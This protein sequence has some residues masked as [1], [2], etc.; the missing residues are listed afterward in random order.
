MAQ[1]LLKLEGVSK[2]FKTQQVLHEIDLEIYNGEFVTLLGPSGCGKTTILRMIGGFET[3]DV[4]TI[5]MEGSNLCALPAN[6][7]AVNTVFQSY[8]LFPHMSVFDNIAFGLKM[9]HHNPS[10]I[11][12]RVMQMLDMVKLTEHAYKKPSQLSGGQQQRVAIARAVINQPKI[13]LL[14]ESLSA[15]D[16]K[17]RK[18]MQI[19]LKQLQR[20]LGIT[21][22]FVTHDQEE[23][24]SMSDRIVV[25]NA[26]HIEQT[27]TPKQIYEEPKNL[28]VA[29]FIGEVNLFTCNLLVQNDTKAQLSHLSST[30]KLTVSRP[31]PQKVNVLIRPE[32]L[33]VERRLEDVRSENYFESVLEE[34]I[35]KGTTIDLLLR[36][37]DGHKI[38]ASEFYNEDSDA[39]EY[40][41]GETLY[42]YWVEG[43]E[44]ILD[45]Q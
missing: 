45:E 2:S 24:L 26:G 40:T 14:D 5:M 42:V 17:L 37:R 12:E 30:F 4:G 36:E 19:E 11:N 10:E 39:L 25:M 9:Q 13:L 15:L 44:V 34:I 1:V 27:G 33:R 18:E 28:F 7:R 8:A 31:L 38:M 29:R 21:F 43:W 20:H 3:P 16:Y 32:D 22:L 41:I 23:A 6:R 35:Y